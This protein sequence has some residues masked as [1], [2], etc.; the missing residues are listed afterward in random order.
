M[1]PLNIYDLA[2]HINPFDNSSPVC[3]G[4]VSAC[5]FSV[6]YLQL[7]TITAAAVFYGISRE[8]TSHRSKR[9]TRAEKSRS[10]FLAFFIIINARTAG[11][12]LTFVTQHDGIECEFYR[13]VCAAQAS[14]THTECV[15]QHLDGGRGRTTRTPNESLWNE[16]V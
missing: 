9:Y 11:V 15:A 3:V 6:F 13:L 1:Q 16:S 4:Q 14:D 2:T 8:P 10:H 7:T 5:D 12:L